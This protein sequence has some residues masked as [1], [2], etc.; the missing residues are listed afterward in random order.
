MLQG[1][2]LWRSQPH[3][4]LSDSGLENPVICQMAVYSSNAGLLSSPVTGWQAHK[5]AMAKQVYMW[6]PLFGTLKE[7]R[8]SSHL[9]PR[10]SV[11]SF[12]LP[13]DPCWSFES[14]WGQLTF[15]QPLAPLLRSWGPHRSRA[16]RINEHSDGFFLA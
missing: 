13:W 1:S 16:S 3:C 14:I 10:H 6:L 8:K 11:Y 12:P 2:L 4:F 9:H 7:K 15:K 5:L